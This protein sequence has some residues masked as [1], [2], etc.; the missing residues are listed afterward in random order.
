M[1]FSESL[2]VRILGDSSGLRR[3]LDEVVRQLGGL[4]ERFSGLS[5]RSDRVG[6]SISDLSQATRPLQQISQ[7]LTRVSQQVQALS[8][9]PIGLNVQPALQALQQ[10]M[11]AARAAAGVLQTLSIGPGRPLHSSPAGESTNISRVPRMAA[12]GLVT[13][14]PGLDRVLTRLSAGEFVI[15]RTS[16]EQ[17]GAVF[18]QDLN[19]RAV[20]P[21][22]P[23]FLGLPSARGPEK[24]V[25]R[26]EALVVPPGP[27]LGL[28]S[29][30]PAMPSR[31]NPLQ[32]GPT[33]QSSMATTNNHFGGITIQ[34]RE[35]ADVGALLRD[36]RLQGVQLRNRR[37]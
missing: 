29:G 26:E 4:Q 15:N 19:S 32:H 6:R 2:T 30:E 23:V 36:L 34:V 21:Q 1:S 14:P 35:T 8:Q 20:L 17:L 7:W 16:V 13:G 24:Q 37:G 5:S 33:L 10:L 28:N 3:E 25:V 11:A 31:S 27:R 12:G 9:T 18:L 22:E